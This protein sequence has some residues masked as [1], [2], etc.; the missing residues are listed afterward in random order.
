MST[1]TPG[2]WLLGQRLA[3]R[4]GLGKGGG[5][6]IC[7]GEHPATRGGVDPVC[8][9]MCLPPGVWSSLGTASSVPSP[10]PDDLSLGSGYH[11]A[12]GSWVFSVPLRDLHL[13]I[14]KLLLG[15]SLGGWSHT[16]PIGLYTNSVFAEMNK[17]GQSQSGERFLATRSLREEG[18]PSAPQAHP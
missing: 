2:K 11:K 7:S 13:A 1:A 15:W 9:V 18:L 16:G 4:V 12:S 8:Q 10:S 17:Q 3:G 14:F 5:V 6:H